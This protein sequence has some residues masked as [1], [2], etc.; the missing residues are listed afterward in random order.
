[1]K[2]YG[3]RKNKYI[4]ALSLPVI[5]VVF[6]T[7]SGNGQILKKPADDSIGPMA[8][9]S[10]IWVTALSTDD[11]IIKDAGLLKTDG[12]QTGE[13]IVNNPIDTV[14][15]KNFSEVDVMPEPYGGKREFYELLGI[16]IRYPD[17]ARKTGVEGTVL[18]GFIVD[19]NG[20]LRNVRV[21]KGVDP[22]CDKDVVRIV[23]LSPPWKPGIKDGQPV[24][25]KLV[26]PIV[27]KLE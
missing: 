19:Q 17:N 4:A 27:Y 2:T 14:D 9:L 7:I 25:V 3:K 24:A 16:N 11:A 8:L 22:E 21:L 20:D 13:T 12:I 1:M 15:Y 18:V 5:A 26:L 23:S 6:F 10:T